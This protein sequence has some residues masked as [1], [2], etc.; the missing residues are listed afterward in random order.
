MTLIWGC[1]TGMES[2]CLLRIVEALQYH[3]IHKKQPPAVTLQVY[4]QVWLSS[5]YHVS[6]S[7][8]AQKLKRHYREKRQRCQQTFKMHLLHARP[9]HGMGVWGIDE[10]GSIFF[11][12]LPSRIF[13]VTWEREM[14]PGVATAEASK[15]HGEW[16]LQL[17]HHRRETIASLSPGILR[18]IFVF[19]FSR[20]PTL[21][22]FIQEV[23]LSI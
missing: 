15:S 20:I 4:G 12:F 6:L 2:V 7:N 13:A 19:L 16:R 3:W 21:C 17:H 10:S 22:S 14:T 18:L 5:Y 23:L 11:F 1:K 8:Y 9:D